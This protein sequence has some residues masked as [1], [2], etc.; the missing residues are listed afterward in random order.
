MEMKMSLRCEFL[1]L[2]VLLITGM[3]TTEGLAQQKEEKIILKVPIAFSTVLPTPETACFF[4]A[5]G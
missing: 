1:I 5:S 3:A 2:A 4:S